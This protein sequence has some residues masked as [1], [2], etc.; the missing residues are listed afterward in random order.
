M[1]HLP[2]TA[3]RDRDDIARFEAEMSLA[4]RLP[5]RSILDVFIAGAAQRPDRIALTQ[6]MTGAPDEQPRRVTY[7]E[8]L[9]LVRRAANLF[10]SLAGPRPGVAYM[11]PS[12]IETHATLWGAETAGYAVPINFLLQTEHIAGLL[13]ASGA[14]IL[15][16]LGPHPVLDIWQKALAL[17]DEVPGLTLIRVA[18]PGTPPVEG[19]IDFHAALM[20][21]PDDRLSFGEPGRD[22]E[23]AA[24]FHTGGTTGTPRLV[25]HTH[26]SQLAAAL[27]GAVL[28]DMR[29]T[30]TLTATLPLFHV[31]G[32]IFCGLSAFM[33]GVGLLI[34]SPGGLRNPAMVQGFWRLVGQYGATLVGAVPTSVGAVLEAPLAGADLSAVRAGFCGAASLPPAVG[35]RFREVTGRGLFEVYGMTEASGLI[36]IDP[37]A[38]AGGIG[39]VGWALPYTRLEVRKL[40]ADGR[41]GEV[42]VTDEVGVITVRGPHVSPGYRDPAHN[43]GVFVERGVLNS[44]D[45]GYTDAQGRVHIAGRAK[46]LIIRSGHNIDPLMIENAM[47]AHPAV[48]L[49]AAVGMPDAYAGELPV[50]YVALRPGAQV[51]EDELRA[52]AQQTIG[53]RPAWPKRIHIVDAIPLTSVGKIY[54]PQLRCD[55]AARLVTSVVRDR[56]GIADAQVQASEGGRRGMRVRVTLPEAARAKVAAVQRELA[57]YLFEAEVAVGVG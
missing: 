52:H 14:R 28:G 24:Y 11:L 10:A 35:A 40:A 37:V 39:S 45:L 42:C 26:R 47:A 49:A 57:G 15:V 29:A 12:L 4:A 30:D 7:R 38:G 44:G 22:D 54:K 46:D 51:S 55:A 21:Q 5:E 50:C 53:E 34:M 2:E 17:R 32:T 48:A 23:V 19:V 25:A 36:A 1:A 3:I 56:L 20:A 6:L 41:L 18:P 8:L 16:A 27:G 13:K 9:G 33:A 43:A 31:G